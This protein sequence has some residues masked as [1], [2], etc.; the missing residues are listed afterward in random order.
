[1]FD[2]QAWYVRDVLMD[3]ISLP[4]KDAMD[5]DVRQ[6]EAEEDAL[7]DD[8]ACVAYQGSYTKELI[9]ETDYPSF[10]INAANEAFYRWKKAKKKDIMTFRDQGGF[11]SPMDN[12][13]S[14]SHHKT[15]RDELDDSMETYL[16]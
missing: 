3:K 1:M 11:V 8:Y 15:W 6:R 16:R 12:S 9:D 10:D 7:E 5:N 14:T 4:S 2:A 13:V